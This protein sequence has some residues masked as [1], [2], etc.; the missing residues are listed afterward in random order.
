MAVKREEKLQVACAN[1]LRLQY[2]GVF[3]FHPP[4]EAKHH[5]NYRARLKL[6]GVRA[7]IPDIMICCRSQVWVGL[8]IELKV[9]GNYPTPAQRECLKALKDEGWFTAICHTIEEFQEEVD[10]YFDK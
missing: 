4:N 7:G 2:R 5:I 1:Y 10:K 8:A 9:K 6:M 3:W